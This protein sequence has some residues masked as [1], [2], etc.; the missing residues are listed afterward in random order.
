MQC[1]RADV[2][3]GSG[4]NWALTNPKCPDCCHIYHNIQ[5]T[6]CTGNTEEAVFVRSVHLFGCVSLEAASARGMLPMF[7]TGYCGGYSW[8]ASVTCSHS[9]GMSPDVLCCGTAE[10]L[11]LP[12]FLESLVLPFLDFPIHKVKAGGLQLWCVG[13]KPSPVRC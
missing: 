11:Q 8:W 10:I 12:G 3:I 13:K 6:N 4:L 1:S 7:W 9:Q 2:G 5:E